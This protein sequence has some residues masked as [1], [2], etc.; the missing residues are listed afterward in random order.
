[1]S[2]SS[3]C[4]FGGFPL[5]YFC[6]ALA[7]RIFVLMQSLARDWQTVVFTNGN[8]AARIAWAM[9]S[10][11]GFS[12]P[13]PN[14]PLAPTAQQPPL[15]PFLLAGIFKLAGVYSYLSLW[16]AVVL[17]AH[18]FLNHCGFG[19]YVGQACIRS[20]CGNYCGLDLGLLAFMKRW[21]QFGSG[22]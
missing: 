1:V 22:E 19:F 13:W 21:S 20:V 3:S 8:E 9:V 4:Q 18:I 10:G 5:D 12:S 16:I 11:H 2:F 7:V 6:V 14:T 15:Y 17:N